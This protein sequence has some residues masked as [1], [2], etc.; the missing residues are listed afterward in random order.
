MI[1][2]GW[3]L[4]DAE[5]G[6]VAA[7]IGAEYSTFRGDK[8]KLIDGYPPR[9]DASTGRV[10]TTQGTYFPSVIGLKWVKLEVRK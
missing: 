5:T 1:R 6:V 9:H 10:E 4:V 2:E 7:E 8:V 3:E